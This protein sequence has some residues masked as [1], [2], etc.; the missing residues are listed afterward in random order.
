M[1]ELKYRVSAVFRRTDV[2]GE[3]GKEGEGR[4]LVDYIDLL[5]PTSSTTTAREDRVQAVACNLDHIMCM[6]TEPK[7]EHLDIQLYDDDHNQEDPAHTW[8]RATTE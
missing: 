7:K 8:L 6:Q 1:G 2:S 3:R 5:S 4:N